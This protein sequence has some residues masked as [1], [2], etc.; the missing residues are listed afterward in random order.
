MDFS[1]YDHTSSEESGE[2][3]RAKNQLTLESA[4]KTLRINSDR[5]SPLGFRKS[6]QTQQIFKSKSG[7]SL[8]GFDL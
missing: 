1:V 3:S 7:H 8:K 2:S 4:T 5:A 6:H